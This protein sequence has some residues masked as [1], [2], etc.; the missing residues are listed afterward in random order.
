MFTQWGLVSHQAATFSFSFLLVFSLVSLRHR[1]SVSFIVSLVPYVL[2]IPLSHLWMGLPLQPDASNT[3]L[4]FSATYGIFAG[5]HFLMARNRNA[6]TLFIVLASLTGMLP[7]HVVGCL[8]FLSTGIDYAS[9][10]STGVT[11]AVTTSWLIGTARK[12]PARRLAIG[13]ASWLKLCLAPLAFTFLPTITI[14]FELLGTFDFRALP[15]IV[16]ATLSL[17]LSYILIVHYALNHAATN[18][19]KTHHDSLRDLERRLAMENKRIGEAHADVIRYRHDLRHVLSMVRGGIREDCSREIASIVGDLHLP[20]IGEGFECLCDDALLNSVLNDAQVKAC[21]QGVSLNIRVAPS[22]ELRIHTVS[23]AA[24]VANLMENAI[25]AASTSSAKTVSVEIKNVKR[26]LIVRIENSFEGELRI[27]KT[28]GLPVS[29]KNDS[30]GWGLINV[31]AFVKE[32]NGIIDFAYE[33][34]LVI[35][36]LSIPLCRNRQDGSR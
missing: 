22:G 10:F 19:I 29:R 32:H 15:L 7:G 34:H 31:G 6:M 16:S 25:D 35:I 3:L 26:N 27:S 28:S 1:P 8:V 2:L 12:H 21:F 11:N 24:A 36:R 9:L 5:S 13:Q 17:Y 18:S 20:D 30:H 23:F 4:S 33:D 14:P